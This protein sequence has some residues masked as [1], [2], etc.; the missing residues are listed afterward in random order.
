MV[1][2]LE[3]F[4]KRYLNV[5][6]P[7]AFS[8][9]SKLKKIYGKKLS[10]KQIKDYLRTIYNYGLHRPY[11]KPRKNQ[12]NPYYTY[13]LR[14]QVQVD[15]AV[16]EYWSS[17][18]LPDS[19]DQIRYLLVCIDIF[20]RRCFIYPLKKKDKTSTLEGIKQI[21]TKIKSIYP[22]KYPQSMCFD[23]GGEFV[24]N[25]VTKHL[26]EN[27]IRPIHATSFVKAGIVERAIRSIKS[28]LYRY[29]TENETY[30]YINVLDKLVSTYNN[31]PHRSLDNFSPVEA[32][33][34]QN[35]LKIQAIHIRRYEKIRKDAKKRRSTEDVLKV[36]QTVR[37]RNRLQNKFRKGF[38]SQ[39]SDE[40]YQIFKVHDHMPIITYSVKSM[41]DNKP[42]RSR[43]YRQQLQPL[44]SDVFR[45]EKILKKRR[46]S[47][48][49]LQLFVKWRHFSSKHNSW[50]D[51]R[52]ITEDFEESRERNSKENIEKEKQKVEQNE[53]FLEL[54]QDENVLR[55]ER[56]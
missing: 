6:D 40:Y 10:V 31:R 1:V 54:E 13:Y 5:G 25:L 32:E 8:G 18:Y 38:H 53:N 47:D 4:T 55:M 29:M 35:Q 52:D 49:S 56:R 2:S 11:F 12:Y 7:T 46:L 17:Y 42:Y 36:G 27:K 24:N 30:R 21:L 15:L 44:D 37:I 39:F 20:S 16:M 23:M 48:G 51:A 19:N 34:E 45:I 28:L 9:I 14:S 50:I 43:L 22:F 41:D 33:L 3:E 26:K